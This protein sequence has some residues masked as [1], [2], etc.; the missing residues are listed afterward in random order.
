MLSIC[1]IV[2]N[3][4]EHLENCIQSVIPAAD[5]IILVDTGSTDRTISIAQKYTSEIF[6]FKWNDD[7]SEARNFA[8][9]KAKGNFIFFIDADEVLINPEAVLNIINPT[10]TLPASREGLKSKGNP[11]QTLP[12]RE[13]L[14]VMSDKTGGYLV[15]IQSV[16]NSDKKNEYFN[17][18]QLRLFR[19]NC[20]FKFEGI[21][22][23]QIINSIIKAGFEI[24]NSNINLQHFGY[25]LK[26]SQKKQ[27]HERN[28]LL[29]DKA[30]KIGITNEL[31][32]YK[33][34]ELAGA[35][36]FKSAVNL[37]QEIIVSE[38]N[39]NALLI[40]SL[41]FASFLAYKIH[42]INDSL[43]YISLSL[44]LS[45]NQIFA[46][47]VKAEIKAEMKDYQEALGHYRAAYFAGQYLNYLTLGYGE[48]SIPV[49]ILKLKSAKILLLLKRYPEA[50]LEFEKILNLNPENKTA[51]IG[52][53]NAN[54]KLNNF[55]KTKQILLELLTKFPQDIEIKRYMQQSGLF[56][57]DVSPNLST[58][59]IKP[60]LTLSMIVKNEEK[61]LRE[62]I[63]SA[64]P[65]VDEIIIVDTGSTDKTKEIAK[66]FGA[67]IFDYQ[68]NNN[69]ADARNEALKHSTG[70]WI[71]Y[72]DAD[73]RLQ[74]LS[75][76]SI[77]N[78]FSVS[79]DE[80]GG[81]LCIIESEHSKDN[82][83]TE[84]HRGGYP[85]IF[86]NYGFPLI[87]FTGKVHEQITPSIKS[88][89]KY[90][91]NSGIVITHLG[92]NLSPEEMSEKV[93]RNYE[94]LIS[95]V[96]EE[97]LNGYAW[98]QMGQ[99]LGRMNLK[100]QSIEAF[101]FA[102]STKSL[103][104]S[105]LSSAYSALAQMLGNKKQFAETLSYAEKSLKLVPDQ[106][107]ANHLKGFALLYL[108][109][110]EESANAFLKVLDL[111]KRTKNLPQTGFDIEIPEK[112]ILEGLEK[113]R[114]RD[115]K[116]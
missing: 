105:I 88:L 11:T 107:Y 115:N 39:N 12:A 3:E 50:A 114:N 59:S 81:F 38:K 72:L 30:M 95:Q 67:K 89:G 84:M 101:Q 103:S 80:I 53:A 40:A 46:N 44:E 41:N 17:S 74:S 77:T 65:I 93:R 109:R 48:Y 52:L 43:H 111:K 33:A 98:F 70:E 76:E 57:S 28:M 94:M 37:L 83:E 5:E 1:I 104:D 86:R 31:K 66:S 26:G 20:N 71:L 112:L 29:I 61:H 91:T 25:D 47:F 7:F 87:Q 36:E 106:L 73:E 108:S 54:F 113:A 55:S 13:G 45:S 19:N 62:C 60:L 82:G 92:Y 16:T 4:E 34:K 110:F 21:V 24:E 22:H 14:K 9:S 6:N 35:N 97:P 27:K 116:I 15:N 2:K 49:E 85:R 90:F 96:A 42:K 56:K 102:I 100:E 69:F 10:Q 51:S 8:L 18:S 63:E 23:E 79:P 78:L 99:T 75:K 58:H 68:W 32:F 64:L